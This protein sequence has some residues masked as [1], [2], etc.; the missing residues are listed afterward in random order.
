M[1]PVAIKSCLFL[2]AVAALL[3]IACAAQALPWE[4]PAVFGI[5]K[6]PP[7]CTSLP[8]A[9]QESARRGD[10]PAGGFYRSLN[11]LWKF[12]WAPDPDGRPADFFHANYDVS[13][14][15]EIAVPANWQLQGYDVPIYTNK[16]YP[17]QKAPPF[18][19]KTPP[20]NYTSYKLRNPVGSYR[21][22]FEVPSSWRGRRIL[23]TFDGVESAFYV[24]IN[25]QSVG[26]SEDSRTPAEFDVTEFVGP[27]RNVLAVEVYRWCDGSYLEDQDFWRLSGIFRDVYLHAVNPVHVRDFFVRTELDQDYRDATL[28]IEAEI[29][30]LTGRERAYSLQARLLDP[31]GQVIADLGA[32]GE[33]S[34]PGQPARS[35][36]RKKIANPLQWSAE[37]PNLY[38]LLLTLKDEK[39]TVLEVR[40]CRVGFRSVEIRNAQLLVNGQPI[41]VKGVNRHEHD[42]DTGH[43]ISRDSMIR[44]ICLMKQNNINTVRT[45]H[46]PNAPLWYDL[47]DEYG[48]YLIDEANIE[49]HG[50]GY[51]PETLAKDPAWAAAHLDRTERMVERDKNHPSVIIWSLG[52]EAGDGPNFQAASAWVHRRDASRPVHYEQAKQEPHTDIVCP[53]YARIPALINY[54]AGPHDRPLILCEYDHA[55]GNSVGNLQDY[56]DVIERYPS[57][58]GGSIW[59]WVDQGLRQTAPDG[60]WFWAYG[61]DF[62]DIP[63][64]NNFCCNGLVQPDR[65]PNPHLEEVRKVYQSIKVY[66]VN[67]DAGQLRIHNKYFFQS[68]D[69]A[70]VQWRVTADG[71][72][73]QSGS[74]API[75]VPPQQQHDLSLPLQP[76]ARASSRQYLLTV[77]FLLHD[78][79]PWAPKGHILAW[80]QFAL[81]W[82][83]AP[84]PTLPLNNL[85]PL[86]LAETDDAFT[87]RGGDFSLSVGRTTGQ[88]DSF[89]FRNTPL[90]AQPLAP[91]LWRVPTDND[92]GNK[93]PARQGLWK[94]AARDRSVQS[95]AATRPDPRIVRIAV[96][97]SLPAGKTTLDAAYTIYAS[98]D[99]LVEYTLNPA[100]KL[101]DLPRVGMQCA[102]PAAFDS[103]RYF[104]RGP[105]ESYCDRKTSA[106]LGLYAARVQQLCHTYVRPQENGNRSDCRFAVLTNP[107]GLGLLIVGMPTFD[108]SAWPYSMADL[109]QAK[110]INELPSRD[111]I[112]VNLDYRQMGVG[113]DDSWGARPHDQYL[114]PADKPYRH[115]FRLRGYAPDLGDID[116]LARLKLPV[117]DPDN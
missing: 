17:F 70:D 45:C 80:D 92:V 29:R 27:G 25:G 72:V 75:V 31:A 110:H 82:P 64:D 15:A 102:L 68:L 23:L 63:N 90:L 111:F 2:S 100:G 81:P 55:M 95:V 39:D 103:V 12:H 98:G 10:P 3:K 9:D 20:Q 115:A 105:H 60:T 24:W 77:S 62:G 97:S 66:P 101:P 6:Q 91:N 71:R 76:P 44:D 74:L 7:R 84:A 46:Y 8:F 36:V 106:A 41:Y 32:A 89:I 19:T 1:M 85:P 51:G 88:L 11:G 58:Q 48:L 56:W 21:T 114:L 69:F 87:V 108:F 49:S 86:E 50:M 94:T 57:L 109:E 13:A 52:N 107:A 59:D 35:V 34:L 43:T 5:N 61:G 53:M 54:A 79:Q 83:S 14:W 116:E 18:V 16:T 40:S 78:G 37:T 93:M 96:R 33:P 30:N 112:T 38:K 67:L 47:C 113:G 99:V 42:P 65:K 73:I 26:Y 117:L 4:D 104:G 28:V 22:D